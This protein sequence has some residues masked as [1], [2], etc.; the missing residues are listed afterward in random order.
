MQGRDRVG[1]R[2]FN[3][4]SNS[5]ML[6]PSLPP[7]YCLSSWPGVDVTCRST[8]PA[9]PIYHHLL[10]SSH[11]L[12]R[13]GSG[14]RSSLTIMCHTQLARPYALCDA[15]TRACEVTEIVQY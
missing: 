9:G 15:D 7:H 2:A 14:H 6:A 11:P 13:A 1:Q 5:A 8:V 12:D 3:H 4:W 10:D